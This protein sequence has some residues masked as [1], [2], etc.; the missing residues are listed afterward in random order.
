[1]KFKQ[2]LLNEVRHGLIDPSMR[3]RIDSQVKSVDGI[4]M[5][6]EF[7]DVNGTFYHK[8]FIQQ[9]PA[10]VRT[11]PGQVIICAGF[12]YFFGTEIDEGLLSN[13][14]VS[15]VAYFDTRSNKLVQGEGKG[16]VKLEVNPLDVVSI[17][18]SSLDPRVIRYMRQE[19]SWFD[20]AVLM[21]GNNI[22]KNSCHYNTD[23]ME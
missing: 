17:K 7:Y 14:L 8:N 22:V 11:H 19:Y 18:S 23:E 15:R 5:K 4:D 13:A 10:N 21:D 1:M 20:F 16:V 9:F 12:G 3:L 2:W 6:Y